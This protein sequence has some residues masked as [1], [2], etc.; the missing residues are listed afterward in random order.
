MMGYH[1]RERYGA[2]LRPSHVSEVIISFH[3]TRN[4]RQAVEEEEDD[5]KIKV[6]LFTIDMIRA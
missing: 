2:E 4:R 6:R 5:V 3:Y 1:M